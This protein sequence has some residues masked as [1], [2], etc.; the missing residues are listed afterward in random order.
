VDSFNTQQKNEFQKE[1][2]ERFDSYTPSVLRTL[3]AGFWDLRIPYISDYAYRERLAVG[4]PQADEDLEE[5]YRKVAAHMAMLAPS[6]ASLRNRYAPEIK[7]VFGRQL[8]DVVV[9]YP[10]GDL[11]ASALEIVERV[12]A[13]SLSVWPEPIEIVSGATAELH[14]T[15]AQSRLVVALT[16]AD[17]VES[18]WLKNAW[19]AARQRGL[20]FYPVRRGGEAAEETSPAPGWMRH[21]PVLELP[22]DWQDLLGRLRFPRV[23]P[24]ILDMAPP[25]AT[26]HVVRRKELDTLS[27]LLRGG[28]EGSSEPQTAVLWGLAGS[29]KSVLAG[30]LCRDEQVQDCFPDGVL[31]VTLGSSPD[32]AAELRRCLQACGRS[33]P[34]HA[35]EVELRRELELQLKTTFGHSCWPAQA[36]RTSSRPATGTWPMPSASPHLPWVSSPPRKRMTS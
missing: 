2:V 7:R 24:R 16:S 11:R 6:G 21:Q 28:A 17:A 30:M 13:A 14:S 34:P 35:V 18:G 20:G 5:A 4:D 29:G 1:F 12:R 10:R 8:P 36:P 32:I 23:L 25:L 15:I 9:V 33:L 3:K 27:G 26:G 31:W 19:R 22:R